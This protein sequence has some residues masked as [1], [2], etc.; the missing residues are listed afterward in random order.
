MRPIPQAVGLGDV[1][2]I[3]WLNT[4]DPS[5]ANEATQVATLKKAHIAFTATSEY[6]TY[7]DLSMEWDGMGLKWNAGG[8][9]SGRR[10][11]G[12]HCRC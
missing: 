5:E 2:P 11:I 12:C 9:G 1:A 4:L 6:P 3:F 7:P 10:L 8:I